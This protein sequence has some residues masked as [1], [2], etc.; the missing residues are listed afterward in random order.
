MNKIYLQTR[1]VEM[2]KKELG[3]ALNHKS[4]LDPEILILS[5]NLDKELNKLDNLKEKK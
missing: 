1:K 5:R 2:L 4:T 3:E